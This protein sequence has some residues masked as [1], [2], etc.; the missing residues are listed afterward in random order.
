[1][2]PR[3]SAASFTDPDSG[4]ARPEAVRRLPLLA[5]FALVSA[6]IASKPVRAETTYG[7][8]HAVPKQSSSSH[9]PDD[10]DGAGNPG[11]SE[12][13]RNSGD[14][15]ES[16]GPALTFNA[17]GKTGLAA[18]CFSM[19]LHPHS[20]GEFFGGLA[21][22]PIWWGGCSMIYGVVMSHV[23]LIAGNDSIEAA[24]RDP[25]RVSAGAGPEIAWLPGTASGSG[26]GAHMDV[27]GPLASGRHG[28]LDLRLR[29]APSF[30]SLG[31]DVDYERSVF[32]DGR[33]AGVENDVMTGYSQSRVPFTAELLWQPGSRGFYLGAGAGGMLLTESI[34][35]EH[36]DVFSLK[37]GPRAQERTSVLPL[38]VAAL[39]RNKLDA[40]GRPR[41]YFEI[42]YQAAFHRPER[43]SSFPADNAWV[44]QGVGWEWG[45]YL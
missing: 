9:D 30:A 29:A 7:E 16:S 26:V 17:E 35:Y 4:R 39:G 20:L 23:H 37:S 32:V 34:Q 44:T 21:F 18:A 41:W 2:R 13:D 43:M 19:E 38:A 25:W 5:A 45:I 42:R 1:M 36:R 3:P 22:M 6:C 12:D 11:R 28:M 24:A 31:M 33:F 27:T 40:F 15:G 14:D 10:D 8:T